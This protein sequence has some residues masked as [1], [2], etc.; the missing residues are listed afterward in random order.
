MDEKTGD[1]SGMSAIAFLSDTMSHR[2]I[3]ALLGTCIAVLTLVGCAGVGQRF[4]ESPYE[5]AQQSEPARA[6]QFLIEPITPQLLLKFNQT[7]D[8]AAAPQANP[9]LDQALHDYTY[10][11]G[12]QDVL[13]VIVWN[14]PE[15]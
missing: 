6:G 4:D 14:H 7:Q 5:K 1:S 10:K 13:R 15:L 2:R 9:A 11:V 8:P 3:T 12:V